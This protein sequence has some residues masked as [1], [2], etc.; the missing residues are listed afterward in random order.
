VEVLDN[1]GQRVAAQ[2]DPMW[3]GKKIAA[4]QF[5][6]HFVAKV[7]GLG[8][9]TYFIHLASPDYTLFSSVVEYASSC[10]SLD[11]QIYAGWTS[12]CKPLGSTNL[13]A[14]N[15]HYPALFFPPTNFLACYTV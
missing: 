12:Y 6:L 2:V 4:S 10:T 13:F 11:G 9:T 5:T 7:T 8:L 14:E 1:Q 15:S 3:E